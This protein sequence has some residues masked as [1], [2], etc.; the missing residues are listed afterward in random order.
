[1]PHLRHNTNENI[2]SI[3]GGEALGGRSTHAAAL[4]GQRENSRSNPPHRRRPL[5]KILD[6][7]RNGPGESV[8][9]NA[10]LRQRHRSKNRQE[11]Q[12][13]EKV[14]KRDA[15]VLETRARP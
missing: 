9:I 12:R 15:P 7:R 6:R 3:G 13:N 8:Q 14:A 4:G 5:R 11:S 1:M 10:L 2:L